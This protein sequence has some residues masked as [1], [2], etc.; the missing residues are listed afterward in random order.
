MKL[1]SA[2]WIQPRFRVGE[3]PERRKHRCA[4]CGKQWS[5]SATWLPPLL[6]C[7]DCQHQKAPLPGVHTRR[8]WV[9]WQWRS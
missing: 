7:A 8:E 9:A 6:E 4:R 1:E 2:N 5:S 3:Y